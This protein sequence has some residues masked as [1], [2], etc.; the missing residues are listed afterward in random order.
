MKEKFILFTRNL[1]ITYLL[2]AVLLFVLAF[3]LY[4]FKLQEKQVLICVYAIYSIACLIGGFLTGKVS[5]QRRFLWGAVFG[6]LFY[7]LLMVVSLIIRQDLSGSFISLLS[8]LAFCVIG[9]M[10]GGIVS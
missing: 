5:E 6:V 10:I 7:V 2:T 4:K 1:F 3:I 8:V 9:G